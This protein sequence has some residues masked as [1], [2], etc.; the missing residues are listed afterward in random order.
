MTMSRNTRPKMRV[1]QASSE[2]AGWSISSWHQLVAGSNLVRYYNVCYSCPSSILPRVLR[3][4]LQRSE[5]WAKTG[6]CVANIVIQAGPLLCCK[7]IQTCT[8]RE[9]SLEHEAYEEPCGRYESEICFFIPRLVHVQNPLQH[10]VLP[11][12]FHTIHSGILCK[13]NE[14][15]PVSTRFRADALRQARPS[16]ASE[17][18]KLSDLGICRLVCNTI[19]LATSQPMLQDLPC[20]LDL[21][22]LEQ[23]YEIL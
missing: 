4:V 12:H 19:P 7:Q 6:A 11:H 22:G 8:H 21:H 5:S 23:H 16:S 20:T 2:H 13:Y 10:K 17:V 14:T 1:G 9:N 18:P 3:I 15:C